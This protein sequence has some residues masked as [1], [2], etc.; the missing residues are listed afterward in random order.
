MY[1]IE[2]FSHNTNDILN[3]NQ[4][5]KYTSKIDIQIFQKIKVII[6]KKKIAIFNVIEK[7]WENFLLYCIILIGTV[8][9][10]T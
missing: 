10:L 6:G 2:Y 8:F 4:I 3:T 7:L 1:A 9:E 5:K